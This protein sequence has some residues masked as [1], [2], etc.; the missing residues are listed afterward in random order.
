MKPANALW[1]RFYSPTR[2]QSCEPVVSRYMK[3]QPILIR[4]VILVVAG[5]TA[6][7]RTPKPD[8]GACK[9]M[10][11]ACKEGLEPIPLAGCAQTHY[12]AA[13]T[14]GG[15]QT[16]NLS[17]DSGSTT[18]AVA[19]NSCTDCNVSP[20]Y[21]PGASAHDQMQ[22]AKAQYYNGASGWSGE[23]YTDSV[24]L[25][26]APPLSMAFVAMHDQTKFFNSEVQCP[27]VTQPVITQGILGVARAGAALPGTDTFMDVL[28]KQGRD[29]TV[30]FALDDLGGTMWLGGY[31]P[32]SVASAPTF[33][34]LLETSS[35]VSA[36]ALQSIYV[37]QA[38]SVSV[39]DSAPSA[40]TQNL[41]L[42]LDTGTPGFELPPAAYAAVVD[43]VTS[44]PGYLANF[45]ASFLS[46]GICTP[47]STATT[48]AE[49]DAALPTLSVTFA[50]AQGKAVAVTLP[51]TAS[52]LQL[53]VSVDGKRPYY[54]PV[55]NRSKI[56]VGLFGATMM[57]SLVMVFDAA[58]KQVGMAPRAGSQAHVD[59]R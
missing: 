27:G 16:F 42:P 43:A 40:A 8:A 25:D 30:S 47:A 10:A 2:N 54:C 19:S 48:P 39:G 14:L 34:P 51:A 52:Y 56:S 55:L 1:G 15:N 3:Q 33:F 35:T 37:L 13:V 21:T 59:A 49:L 20:T 58:N 41:V 45:T 46:T 50:D 4:C 31:D 28:H 17:I 7:G 29:E 53:G 9:G 44:N 18:M 36:A 32:Q 11:G 5:L 57:R 38:S 26:G 24:A 23:V 12:V 6:C 22:S